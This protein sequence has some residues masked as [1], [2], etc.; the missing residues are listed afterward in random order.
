M[1]HRGRF[2]PIGN[3]GAARVIDQEIAQTSP[4]Y[5]R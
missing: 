3:I 2:L 4:T 5:G 1:A